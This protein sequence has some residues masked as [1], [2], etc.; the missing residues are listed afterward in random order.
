MSRY[1]TLKKN[2][3][4]FNQYLW[5]ICD[6]AN[7]TALP[8]STLNVGSPEE[9]ITFE[10]V[11]NSSIE[12]PT[13]SRVLLNLIKIKKLYL[14]LVP[15][16]YV[17]IKNYVD[18]RFFD[19]LSFAL[20]LIAMLAIFIGFNIRNDVIDHISG[21]DRVNIN[22]NKPLLKGWVNT[23]FASR[24][25]NFFIGLALLISLPIVYRQREEGRVIIVVTIL[26]FLGKLL[27]KNSYKNHRW[28]EIIF[29]VL[30]G[31][32]V[33]SG[34]QVALG[35]GI[36]TEV[37]AFGILWAWSIQFLVHLNNFSHLLTSAQA[38]IKNTMTRYGFDGAKKIII[39]WWIIFV[40]LWALYHYFYSSVF[41]GWFTTAILIFW[42]IP[43]VIKVDQIQSPL[44]SDTRMIKKIGYRNFLLM[45]TLVIIEFTWY[46]LTKNSWTP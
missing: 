42:S 21:Y 32:G 22:H 1:V 25:S 16:L 39:Y 30:S 19:P 44:G 14:V 36:D 3:P 11:E 29:F 35:A 26:L 45:T 24:L 8:M 27:T 10:I 4:L 2:D 7:H 9:T 13:Q 17:A 37:L 6:I 18:D 46:W 33:V 38:G 12:K 34:Y 41:W 43:T 5:G 23:H 20:S 31:P 40:F 15:F 28:G